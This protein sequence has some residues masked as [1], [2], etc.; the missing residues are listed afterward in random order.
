MH[1]ASK[2][3]I[4]TLPLL[5]LASLATAD[6][7]SGDTI[8]LDAGFGY[9]TNSSTRKI[10]DGNGFT[11]GIG[12]ALPFKGVLSPQSGRASIDVDWNRNTGKGNTFNSVAAEYVERIPLSMST[13]MN[14]NQPMPYFGIGV[15]AFFDNAKV[16]GVT[17]N[18]TEFGGEAMLGVLFSKQFYVEAS[19]RV[20]GEV[21]KT[22]VDNLNLVVGVRF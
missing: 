12:Y 13:T 15:G 10:V 11:A 5:A 9:L 6:Y 21:N 22:N 8:S 1:G 20:S 2:S 7:K 17:T 19:Y 18:K 16:G 14:A 4:A 3:L